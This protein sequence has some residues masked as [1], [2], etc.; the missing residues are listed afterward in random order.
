MSSRTVAVIG[1]SKDRS[2][3]GNKAV[4]AYLKQGWTVYPVN[5]NETEIEG[6]PA[7]KSL[8]SVPRPVT[9]VTVYLP[10]RI[11][12]SVLEEIKSLGAEEV[13]FNPGSDAPEVIERASEL[14]LHPI[15]ACS[16]IDI[17]ESPS[18]YPAS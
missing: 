17:G 1:A 3:Y 10:P 11:G 15:V 9:R 5:P 2:K 7:Y 8:D 18:R 14:G 12:L 6:L 4:R 16:I 13:F